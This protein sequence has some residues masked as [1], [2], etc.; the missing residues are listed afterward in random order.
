MKATEVV[1]GGALTEDGQL[2]LDEKPNL[3][4]GRVKVWL[5]PL[6]RTAASGAGLLDSSPRFSSL[7]AASGTGPRATDGWLPGQ[8]AAAVR[9]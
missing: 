2:V 6:D 9:K 8:G 4:P 1:V 3:P 5:R 7:H